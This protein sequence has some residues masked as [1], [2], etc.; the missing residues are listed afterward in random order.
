M[1][2]SM[3]WLNFIPSIGLL[4][5][6]IV[7]ASAQARE[8]TDK[9]NVIIMYLDDAGYGDFSHN[10]N[11]V[12][13]TPEIAK[14]AHEG[15]NF[16][17]F[18]VTAP[19]CS[20][21]RYSLLTGRYPARSGLGSWVIGPG[22][23]KHLH[24]KEQTLAEVL[25]SHG[26]ATGMFGK[27]HLGNANPANRMSADAFPPAHG[28]D[29]WVGTNVSHDY[30]NAMLMQFDGKG[31]DPIQGYTTLAKNL[32]SDIEASESLVGLYA[33][34]AVRFIED[35][36]DRPFFAYVAHNQPH[37]GVFA[38]DAFKGKSRRGILGD[39]MAEVDDSL[40]QIRQA[41]ENA[42]IS[43]NTII[44]FSSDN[45][46]WVMFRDKANTKYGEARMHV[47]YAMP[48]RDGKGSNWEGGHR[49]PGIF[50]WPGVIKPGN[51]LQPISTLDIL[52][53]I[54]Q[55]TGASKPDC[56]LDGRDV[57]AYL[58]EEAPEELPFTLL[59]SGGRNEANAIRS[60]SWKLHTRLISQL[61]T[62]HGF[63]ASVDRPILFNV[64]QDLSE[65]IDRAVEQPE[66]VE[67]LKAK[68][69][70]LLQQIESEG[71]Y[72]DQD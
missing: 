9:P 66:V 71:S 19:A 12:I 25:K 42:G 23:K 38:S 47:G 21:S 20:V 48:F 55:L 26:Y 52:P 70:E 14:L 17:Q 3:K 13:E 18:Y 31:N 72:W 39:A 60:G 54:C 35:N 32:P 68:R 67:S 15:A 46:P 49:V 57:S 4:A 6:G 56:T 45:G 58:L 30:G 53:T 36:K 5:A 62:T 22:A 7:G 50:C 34:E 24:P 41:L 27:W 16:T 64:E 11:P 69:E 1:N 51:K 33:K 44:I 40:R 61:G 28:F 29:R 8:A 2:R 43:K 63:E 65:R 37:L 10:G 59:Y